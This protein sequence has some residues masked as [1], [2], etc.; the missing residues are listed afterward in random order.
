MG[1]FSNGSEGMDFEETWCRQCVHDSDKVPCP[2]MGLHRDWNYEQIVDGKCQGDKA[3]A[4]SAFI[5]RHGAFNLSCVMWF[6]SQ[7]AAA[8]RRENYDAKVKPIEVTL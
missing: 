6:P 3:K 7:E 4:L 1:Y 8:K 5:P 2:I